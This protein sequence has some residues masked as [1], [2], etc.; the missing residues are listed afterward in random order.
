MPRKTRRVCPTSQNQGCGC[1]LRRQACGRRRQPD[2]F[3]T[4]IRSASVHHGGHEGAAQVLQSFTDG[5]CRMELRRPN[6]LMAALNPIGMARQ[7]LP[8]QPSS[9]CV[10]QDSQRFWSLVPSV[11]LLYQP[12]PYWR[13]RKNRRGSIAAVSSWRFGG[14]P[15]SADWR[16]FGQMPRFTNPKPERRSLLGCDRLHDCARRPDQPWGTKVSRRYQ[17]NDDGVARQGEEPHN[18]RGR[19]RNIW[20]K[21]P[22]TPYSPS[23]RL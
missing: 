15:W 7:P 20:V 16:H 4:G 14:D 13:G 12:C 11:S 2:Y 21:P 1:K 18:R 23:T 19:R 10:W 17:K 6:S 22:G 9:R 8:S 3:K 5:R